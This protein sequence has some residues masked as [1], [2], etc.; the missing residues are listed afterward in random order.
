MEARDMI[1]IVCPIGCKMKVSE[2]SSA[3]RG[4]SV[5]GNKC[6]RGAEYAIKELKNPTRVLTSTVA[7]KEG[8]LDRLPVKSS[9]P[10]SKCLLKKAMEV[11]NKIEI[12]APV[13]VGDVIVKNILN[14]G[15]DIVSSK[16]MKKV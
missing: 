7:I 12:K 16:S 15:V 11:I 2:D 13:S 10:I 1:C 8:F 4:V 14:T 3:E 5:E 6:P 9:E